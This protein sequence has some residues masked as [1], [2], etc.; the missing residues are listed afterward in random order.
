M[1]E[2]VQNPAAVE[3]IDASQRTITHKR[4][5]GLTKTYAS[6]YQALKSVD[7]EI[8]AGEIFGLLGPNGAGKSTTFKML[9]GLL[10]PTSGT[11]HVMGLDLRAA[12]S[13]AASAGRTGAVY[14]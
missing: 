9:C 11:A 2:I 8:R 3:S 10:K 4:I 5:D 12:T 7:L 1:V 13:E 6:G 14:R